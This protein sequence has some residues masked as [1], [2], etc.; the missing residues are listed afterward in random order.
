MASLCSR[1][2]LEKCHLFPSH[3]ASSPGAYATW[4]ALVSPCPSTAIPVLS[5]GDRVSLMLSSQGTAVRHR[6]TGSWAPTRLLFSRQRGVAPGSGSSED[7]LRLGC[8][9]LQMPARNMEIGTRA[10]MGDSHHLPSHTQPQM[11]GE[12]SQHSNVMPATTQHKAWI[13]VDTSELEVP[14]VQLGRWEWSPCLA[15]SLML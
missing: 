5:L 2:M 6:L 1:D 7:R 10:E 13:K 9:P 11:A 8:G 14:C 3:T 4:H 12:V 15:C